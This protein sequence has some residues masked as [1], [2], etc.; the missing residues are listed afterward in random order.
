MSGLSC[1]ETPR[2]L[3]ITIK[4]VDAITTYFNYDIKKL[5]VVQQVH[6]HLEPLK[7]AMIVDRVTNC[8]II[9]TTSQFIIYLMF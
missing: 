7:L 6:G 8:W 2:V 4:K 5:V 9:V 1:Y 3:Y